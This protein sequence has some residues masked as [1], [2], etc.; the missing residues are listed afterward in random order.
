MAMTQVTFAHDLTD[1]LAWLLA[2]P[3][4]TTERITPLINLVTRNCLTWED[5]LRCCWI[6]GRWGATDGICHDCFREELRRLN[7]DV[8]PSCPRRRPYALVEPMVLR[9]VF[10]VAQDALAGEPAERVAAQLRALVVRCCWELS[11][12]VTWGDDEAGIRYAQC[13]VVLKVRATRVFDAA[14]AHGAR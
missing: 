1:E 7:A 4:V 3:P 14:L 9:E 5:E 13:V 2:M 12:Y 11:Q 8:L 10:C 6:C